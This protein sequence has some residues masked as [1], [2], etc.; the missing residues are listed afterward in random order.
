MSV[1]IAGGHG[2]VALMV[3]RL[4]ADRGERVLGII[5]RPEQAGAVRAAGARTLVSD[6]ATTTVEQCTQYVDGARAVLFAAGAGLGDALGRADPVDHDAAVAIADAAELAGVRR[7]VMLSAMGADPAR[8][9]PVDPLVETFLRAK[10]RADENLVARG[11]LD[12]TVV[13]PGWFRDGPRTGGVHLAES[14]GPGEI[15]RADV[16]AVLAALLTVSSTT[17]RVLELT[18]G[19]TPVAEAVARFAPPLPDTG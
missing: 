15:A 10:G 9:Y 19:T 8:H 7:F 16:A 14:T 5:R 1:V 4:L 3:S 18:A 12:T 2:R 17:P 11:A 6:L 13:R